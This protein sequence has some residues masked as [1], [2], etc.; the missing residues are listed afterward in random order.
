MTRAGR[1]DWEMKTGP[2]AQAPDL[3]GVQASSWKLQPRLKSPLATGRAGLAVLVHR[4]VRS[5]SL[6][7]C[8]APDCTG[9]F[10]SLTSLERSE[11]LAQAL[12]LLQGHCHC[13]SPTVPRVHEPCHSHSQLL[14]SS[15]VVHGTQ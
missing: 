1:R 5:P 7:H 10:T 4:A 11:G 12:A 6:Q 13:L 15:V 8:K 14:T 2:P 3:G 9:Q